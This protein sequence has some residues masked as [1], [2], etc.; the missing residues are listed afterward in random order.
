MVRLKTYFQSEGRVG[1]RRDWELTSAATGETFGRAT[2][3]WVMFNY[4][5]RRLGKMPDGLR[6]AY[7]ALM[8]EPPLHVIA[9]DEARLKLPEPPGG[10]DGGGAAT[11]PGVVVRRHTATALDM[12]MNGHVNNTAFL[13]WVLHSLP[14]ELQL[15][16]LVVQYEVDYKAE[17]V[18]GAPPPPLCPA[19]Y[20]HKPHTSPCAFFHR[21]SAH[22][23]NAQLPTWRITASCS[24]EGFGPL[25]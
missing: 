20:T 1:A 11:A 2:S 3:S 23:S 16:G 19:T 17:A 6:D 22:A 25:L 14:D 5:T 8:P 4:K 9:P 7:R 13:T 21:P 24:L 15:S 12:D 10:A 18:A